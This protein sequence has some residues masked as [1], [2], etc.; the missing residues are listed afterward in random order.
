[1]DKINFLEDEIEDLK[2]TLVKESSSNGAIGKDATTVTGGAAGDYSHSTNGFAGGENAV[3]SASGAVQL[4]EGT[5]NEASTLKFG[6]FKLVDNNGKIPNDRLNLDDEPTSQSTNPLT[7]GSIYSILNISSPTSATLNSTYVDVSAGGNV[8]YSKIGNLVFVN[9]NDITFKSTRQDNGNTL[10]SNL[11]KAL[12]TCCFCLTCW[13]GTLT[14]LRVRIYA[15]ESEI[16]N[17][18]S[19]FTPS[20]AQKWSGSFVYLCK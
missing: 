17:Y 16:K 4:G 18:W 15:N 2:K 20:T 19:G 1:M 6:S 8:I 13:G 14:T 3:A 5:N 10:I 9:I 11:P 12:N 7:S